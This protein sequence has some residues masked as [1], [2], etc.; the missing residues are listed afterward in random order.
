MPNWCEGVLKIRG[1]KDKLL[2]FLTKGLQPLSGTAKKHSPEVDK[3]G[4]IKLYADNY[5]NGTSRGFVYA[6]DEL[7]IDNEAEKPVVCVNAKFSWY[8][9]SNEL[10]EI[11]KKYN[12]DMKIYAFE[13]GMCFNQDLEIVDGKIV[14]NEIIKFED[15][16]WECINPIIGG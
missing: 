1:E 14:R 4:Y 12:V 9:R 3:Y 2:E 15:Y 7:W 5:I 10:L 16:K 8:I 6:D 11:C 13:C